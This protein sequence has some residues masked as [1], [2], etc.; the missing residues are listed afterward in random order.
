MTAVPA[1]GYV[2]GITARGS[3][4]LHPINLTVVQGSKWPI[5]NWLTLVTLP[6]TSG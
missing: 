3:T 4:C 2:V 5:S 6:R 1:I